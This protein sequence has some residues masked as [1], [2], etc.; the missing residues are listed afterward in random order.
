ME[1]LQL[2]P[3]AT[4]LVLIDL[5]RG[6][7][8]RETAP[9][10]AKD[11]V[12]QARRLAERCRKV[13]A[14][15]ILVRVA[16]A[17]D[18]RDRLAPRADAAGWGGPVPPDYSQIVPELGPM[19]GDLVV[20]KRQWGAFYGTEL[21]L[22]LRRRRI[23]TIVLGGIATSFGVEST[24]RAAYERGYE[25]VFVEDAMSGLTAEAHRFAVTTIFPRI[26]TVRSTEEV[27]AALG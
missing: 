15:V 4:A 16:F 21:D 24:A 2:D 1:P 17:P 22:E 10:A 23:R 7:I 14:Q 3:H 12:S 27:L 13:G 9:H 11:V 5:Q 26:G 18:G 19:E 20:T 6:I 25:Q 8:G